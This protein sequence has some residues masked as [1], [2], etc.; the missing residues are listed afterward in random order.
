MIYTACIYR[1]R[2]HLAL[3]RILIS[4][5]PK[6]ST[7]SRFFYVSFS[8]LGKPFFTFIQEL[9]SKTLANFCCKGIHSLCVTACIGEWNRLWSTS[10]ALKQTLFPRILQGLS[11]HIDFSAFYR[12][13]SKKFGP[14]IHM[15]LPV[16]LWVWIQLFWSLG[17][18]FKWPDW[19]EKANK[20]KRLHAAFTQTSHNF[21]CMSKFYCRT[22]TAAI[23]FHLIG[24]VRHFGI[25]SVRILV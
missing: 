17:L 3:N 20:N 7:P 22:K 12:P 19:A 2:T 25:L 18:W 21:F 11:L 8:V 15:S 4:W 24:E 9:F 10:L 14:G 6:A 1:E 5:H 16:I 13:S 23:S